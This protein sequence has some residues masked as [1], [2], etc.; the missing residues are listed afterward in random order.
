MT[1]R[2]TGSY[3]PD[4]ITGSIPVNSMKFRST[5]SYE[6]DPVLLANF[7]YRLLFRSTGSYEP[8]QF[9]DGKRLLSMS[10]D[11]QALTSLTHNLK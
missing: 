10:F 3:E 9:Y 8:D 7:P 11:P 2:S 4:R 1:F 5:G 6:P